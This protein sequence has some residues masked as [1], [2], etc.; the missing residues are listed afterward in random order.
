MDKKIFSWGLYDFANSVIIANL[1]LYFSQWVIVDNGFEDIW[2]GGTLALSTILLIATAPFFGTYSDRVQKRMGFIIPLTL[3]MGAATILLG[4][5]GAANLPVFTKVM[6][7]LFLFLIIQYT[8]QL[9]LVFYDALLPQLT[10]R[11]KFGRISGFGEALGNLGFLAGLF[12][13]FPLISGEIT[14]FGEAGRIQAFLPS[15]ILFFLLAFPMLLF[16]KDRKLEK[17]VPSYSLR[18]TLQNLRG[19]LKNKNMLW[20]LIA[21]HF[22][23]DAI[24]TIQ[25]FF[26]I[27]FDQV[28]NFPDSLKIAA[29]TLVVVFM[30]IGAG[31]MGRVSDKIG[32]QKSL[33]LSVAGLIILFATFPLITTSA[34]VWAQLAII[35]IF[36]GAF[37]AISRALLAKLAPQE[38]RTEFFS[39]FTIFRRFAS[40]VGPIVWGV[41]VFLLASYGTDKY[42]ISIYPLILLMLFGLL[43]LRKVREIEPARS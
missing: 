27:Y 34:L 33:V 11:S 32:Y 41:S 40:V 30:V 43:L 12:L 18:E 24:L 20:F 13:T 31:L 35:G 2:Y 17:R 7:G 37:Y 29:T 39:L 4:V 14:L 36:W 9:S 23:S 21:F 38:R 28:L 22:I 10:T 16:V 42:R 5:F 8:Y 26:P 19:L 15:G 25:T 1:T 3:I 6:L